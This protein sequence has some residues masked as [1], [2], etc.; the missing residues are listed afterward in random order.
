MPH[1]RAYSI[2]WDPEYRSD[3]K[4]MI[5]MPTLAAD[6]V[7]RVTIDAKYALIQMHIRPYSLCVSPPI[8]QELPSFG[9]LIFYTHCLAYEH[10]LPAHLYPTD[11]Q[12]LVDPVVKERREFVD[13]EYYA[14]IASIYEGIQSIRLGS[15]AWTEFRWSG[16]YKDVNLE[17]TRKYSAPRKEIGLYSSAIRQADPLSEFLFY[18][19]VIE[20]ISHGNGKDWTD[21]NL[22]K[23][24]NHNFG[25][26]HIGHDHES[27]YGHRRRVNLFSVYRRRALSRLCELDRKI[28]RSSVSRYLYNDNRCAIAHGVSTVKEYDFGDSIAEV[29]RDICI[30]K[31]LA[32]TAIDEMI[33][34]YYP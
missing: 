20:S 8:G 15:V 32:R 5:D 18:Y 11:G 3:V 12:A 26:L 16:L 29:A 17:Y 2:T 9:D 10:D 33:S 7:G 30:I 21:K 25:F 27:D 24:K 34:S 28:G 4:Y 13:V 23:L 31:L 19:R 14:S 1:P 22:P 6:T